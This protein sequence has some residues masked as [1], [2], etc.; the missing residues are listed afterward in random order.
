M[1]VEH[2]V[3]VL[4]FQRK[5]GDVP[6]GVRKPCVDPVLHH[7]ALTARAVKLPVEGV[8]LVHLSS[9]DVFLPL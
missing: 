7:L 2:T 6:F 9:Q 4:A 8:Q 1:R 3:A 5:P